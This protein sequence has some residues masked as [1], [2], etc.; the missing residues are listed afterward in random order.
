[1]RQKVFEKHKV[2]LELELKIIGETVKQKKV[3]VVLG[4]N[5]KERNKYQNWQGVFLKKI[6]LQSRLFD[7][8]IKSFFDIKKQSKYY[9]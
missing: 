7:P 9:F 8:K 2:K 4:G 3:L 1:M 6:R 5:S